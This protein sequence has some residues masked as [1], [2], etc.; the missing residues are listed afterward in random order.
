MVIDINLTQQVAIER[1][2]IPTP[3]GF[4]WWQITTEQKKLELRNFMFKQ[5]SEDTILLAIC[6]RYIKS[7]IQ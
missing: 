7:G 4:L 5:N 1:R 2:G 3:G 6:Y